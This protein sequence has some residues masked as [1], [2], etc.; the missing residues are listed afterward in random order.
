MFPLNSHNLIDSNCSEIYYKYIM[1]RKQSNNSKNE[2]EKIIIDELNGKIHVYNYDELDLTINK[3]SQFFFNKTQNSSDEINCYSCR[4]CYNLIQ[5][6]TN[7]F[8]TLRDG[9]ISY[10]YWENQ[11][12]EKLLGIKSNEN[13]IH[14]FNHLSRLLPNDILITNFLVKNNI[15]I[16]GLNGVYFNINIADKLL[17]NVLKKGVAENHVHL[18]ASHNFAIIWRDMMQIVFKSDNHRISNDIKLYEEYIYAASVKRII[19]MKYLSARFDL[20]TVPEIKKNNF[21]F[22]NANE[23]ID[24]NLSYYFA[25]NDEYSLD[26]ISILFSAEDKSIKTYSENI[27]LYKALRHLKDYDEQWSKEDRYNYRTFFDCFMD[28]LRI[29]NF[30]YT[31]ITQFGQIKD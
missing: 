16:Q 15:D 5:E 26:K 12:E 19:L 23:I 21:S 27:F 24:K 29:K 9:K 14:V 1:K 22:D 30:I 20:Q 10:K 31:K 18:G 11:S 8:I 4:Y 6:L 17:E 3:F 28:Y 7:A 25:K 2:F 13:K